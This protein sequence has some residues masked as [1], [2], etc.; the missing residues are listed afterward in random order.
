MKQFKS[1]VIILLLAILIIPSVALASWWNPFSWN[2]WQNIW[3][4]IF[5]KQ[6]SVECTKAKDCQ[7]IHKNC[8]YSCSSNKCVQINTFVALRP[9]PDCSSAVSCTPNWQ[10]GWGECKNGSQSQIAIDSNNCGLPASGAKIA[11]PALAR[12]C[13]TKPSITSILP[14]PATIGSLITVTGA[15]LNGFE[16]DKNLWIENSAGKKGV[17]YGERD[18]ST[19]TIKFTLAGSYCTIDTSYSGLPCPSSVIITP[20]T[21]NIYA[22]PWGEMSNTVKFSVVAH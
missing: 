1:F 4:S 8:Y 17:I 18:D 9:Y 13:T 3:N 20:G 12:I 16:G 15:N 5:H 14:N 19:T 2:I 22:T 21:Y 6:V 10:C 11:C 7:D